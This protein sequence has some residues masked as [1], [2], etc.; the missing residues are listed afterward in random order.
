MEILLQDGIRYFEYDF[1]SE[2]DFEMSVFK[3]YQFLFG[4]ESILLSKR[5]IRTENNIG[6]IPDGFIID[7]KLGKWYVLEVELSQHDLY[8]HI[9]PQIT[10]FAHAINSTDTKRN[11]VDSFEKEIKEDQFKYAIFLSQGKADIFKEITKI[12]EKKPE[13]IIILEKGHKD[14]TPVMNNLP[15]NPIVKVFRKFV[16]ENSNLSDCIYL[17]EPI[18]ENKSKKNIIRV[19]SSP[20]QKKDDNSNINFENSDSIEIIE[21]IIMQYEDVNKTLQKS[22]IS[23]SLGAKKNGKNFVWIQPSKKSLLIYFTNGDYNDKLNKIKVNNRGYT[24]IRFAN[25]EVITQI[26]YIKELIE[27]A[28]RIVAEK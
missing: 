8:S 21:K 11:L 9:V 6:G 16:R 13:L 1:K 23:Y 24:T 14:I 5:K 26:D 20:I 2:N 3:E 17:F 22:M 18:V 4:A 28:F 19:S 25:D 12:I 7:P 27:T 15:F 10:K